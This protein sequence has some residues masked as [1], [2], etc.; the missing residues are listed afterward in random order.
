MGMKLTVVCIFL[1]MA[2][3]GMCSGTS[4][5]AGGHEGKLVS[6]G[7]NLAKDSNGPTI[8]L[9]YSKEGFKKNPIG[10]FMYFVPL[11]AVSPV[12]RQTSANN[13]QQTG[14]ISYEKQ[15]DSK[16]FRV[17]CEFEIWGKG[18]HRNTFEPKGMLAT[19]PDISK[20]GKTL[21]N[22][23]DYI[24]FEGNGFGRIEVKGTVTGSTETVTEVDLQFNARGHKSPVTVGLYDVKPK[25]GHYKYENRSNQ[26]V[27]R[28]NELIFKK[29]NDPR[30]GM[31]L[32]SINKTEGSDSYWGSI[33]GAIANLFISPT[34]VNKLGNETMLDFGH[35]LL[36]KKP[37]FTFPKAKNLRENKP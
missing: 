14:I 6:D 7:N 1:L 27:A 12:D 24:K 35:A 34:E 20:K 16:S 13:E 30:M 19:R 18:S 28:V 37:A 29:S 21:T 31:K 25:D 22:M 3:V 10:S 15:A 33:K 4:G 2:G 23:L 9:G 26:I 17:V 8:A 11:I 5:R 36:K 32:A